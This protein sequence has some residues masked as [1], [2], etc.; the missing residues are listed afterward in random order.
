MTGDAALPSVQLLCYRFGPDTRFEGQLLGALERLE[1]AR[2]LRVLEALFIQNDP[3]TGE[4]VAA[5]LRG[6]SSGKFASSMLSF[7]L[8]PSERRRITEKTLADD[9]RGI[10]GDTIRTIGAALAPGA[11]VA[12][13]LV[14]HT[15]LRPLQ[16][17][18]SRTGGT[19]TTSQLVDASELS[20]LTPDLLAA[21]EGTSV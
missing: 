14:D 1:S 9:S 11:S 17:A 6:D 8:D 12:A 2:T 18:A 4:L 13:V 7:R 15:W 21:V 16:D 20:Q 3:D 5:N 10:S 19:L